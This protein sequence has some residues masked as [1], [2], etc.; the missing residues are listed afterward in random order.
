MNLLDTLLQAQGGGQVQQLA[1][2]FGLSEEQA[3]SAIAALVP[4]LAGGLTNN[5]TQP[6]GLDSLLGALTGGNHVK[7]LDDPAALAHPSA[8]QD[9]TGILGHIFGGADASQSISNQASAQTGIS[10]DVLSGMLPVLATMVM[11][12]LSRRTQVANMQPGAAPGG[13]L[14][15]MLTSFL[16]AGGAQQGS[17]LN[18]VLGMAQKYFNK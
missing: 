11:G 1:Q 4:S 13:D 7:Y 15:G 8:V 12:A 2:Q 5:V 6:G 3:S 14:A 9:G 17:T 18:D 16:G 10:A